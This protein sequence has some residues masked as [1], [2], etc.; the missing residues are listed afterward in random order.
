MSEMLPLNKTLYI[1]NTFCIQQNTQTTQ[2][3]G[4]QK[5]QIDH[6]QSEVR[7]MKMNAHNKGSV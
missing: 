7:S 1:E 4:Q 3:A 2:L 6:T 5:F